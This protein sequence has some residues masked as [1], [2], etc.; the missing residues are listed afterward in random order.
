I[1]GL[2]VSMYTAIFVSRV[3]FDIVEKKRWV[4]QLRMMQLIGHTDINFIRWLAPAVT[5]SV[6]II[7]VG[8]VAVVARG[9]ELLDI[10]FTGGSSLQLVC[11]DGKAEDIAQVRE[12]VAELPDVAVSSVCENNLQY[13]VDTSDLDIRHV[14][15]FLHKQFGD[16]LQTYSMKFGELA[17]IEAK[18]S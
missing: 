18:P 11:A 7:A 10:D 12:K 16:S 5:V 1:L 8:L 9:T 17:M 6:I 2:L 3:I 14:Q 4:T 13:K 15:R